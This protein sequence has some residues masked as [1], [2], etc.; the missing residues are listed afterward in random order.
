MKKLLVLIT[1]LL[2]SLPLFGQ[3][4]APTS[5]ETTLIMVRHAE[6]MDDGTRDPS[7]NEMGK[8]RAERLA[9]LLQEDFNIDAVYSTPYKRTRET[10]QPMADYIE[11]EIQTYDPRDLKGFINFLMEAKKGTTVLV[12][13]HSN[14]TPNL[15]NVVLGE[16]KY[17]QLDESAY[18]DIFI[19]TVSEEGKTS[20]EHRTY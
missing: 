3:S 17:E 2:L 9:Q 18:G 19:V 12:V 11:K 4:T 8:D 5:Q 15:V 6:K 20:V 1:V 16:E 13:G 7:L 14:T 10:A